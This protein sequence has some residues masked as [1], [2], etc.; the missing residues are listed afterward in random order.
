MRENLFTGTRTPR[1]P[2]DLRER[3]LQAARAAAGEPVSALERRWHP[4]AFD[5]AWVTALLVL[6]LCHVLVSLPRR[7]SPVTPARSQAVAEERQ[8]EKELGLKGVPM[9]VAGQ[10][11]ARN[12]DAQ[13]QL[14]E[15]LERL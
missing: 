2:D 7:P 12:G 4:A 10:D 8:L 1:P 11:N 5:L 3:A 13:K 14:M 6:V 9:A 15:E